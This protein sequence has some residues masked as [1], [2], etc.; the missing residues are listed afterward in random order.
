[1]KPGPSDLIQPNSIKRYYVLVK[2][3]TESEI[4]NCDLNG[5]P[6][7]SKKIMTNKIIRENTSQPAE[8]YDDS[9]D[10]KLGS[11]QPA[12]VNISGDLSVYGKVFDFTAVA[13]ITS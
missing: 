2:S 12:K 10:I 11:G 8:I 4:F 9:D 1:M 5:Q 6:I 7:I 3:N 13:E